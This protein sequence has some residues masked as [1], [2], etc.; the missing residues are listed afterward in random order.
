VPYLFS[1]YFILQVASACNVLQQAKS[2]LSTLAGR[3]ISM[4]VTGVNHFYDRVLFAS[5]DQS[6]ALAEYA[7]AVRSLLDSF[8]ADHCDFKPHVTI[9]KLTRENDRVVGS[10]RVPRWLYA[11]FKNKHFGKQPVSTIDLCA[12]SHCI[13]R[14]EG[15][16]YVTPLHMDLL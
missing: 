13:E 9:L 11:N 12:M 7:R 15:E 8:I 10:D 1:A 3:G 2:D 16:F 14:P 6:R 5:V 4:H